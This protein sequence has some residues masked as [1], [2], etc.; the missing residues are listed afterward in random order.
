MN[1]RQA[2]WRTLAGIAAL[3]VIAGAGLALT[4]APTTLHIPAV[5]VGPLPPA[6]P[7]TSM[8]ISALPTGT[9]ETPAMLAFRGGSWSDVRHFAA[10]AVLVQH[11]NGNLLIDTGFG[12]HVGEHMKMLPSIQ[13]STHSTAV[14][15]VD[16]LASGGI[17]PGSLAGVIPTHAH[18]DH[19]SGLDDLGNVPVMV[20]AAAKRWIDTKAKGTEVI[21]SLRSINYRQYDFTGGPYLG[22]PR[23]HD[24][25]GDGSVVIVPAP[26]HTPD[27]VVV[28]ISLPS[29]TRYALVGDLVWQMEGIELPADKPWMLRRLIGENSAEVHK[30][31][32]I[33]RSAIATYPQIHA[34]PAHDAASFR[35]IPSFPAIAQ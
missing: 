33:L 20:S 31:I 29:G 28:F 9:Y 17:Q 25:W 8:S 13:R 23:S 34:I 18:W 35:L 15:A 14:A 12:K 1:T 4:F 16:Q 21:N 32:A 3:I 22:F 19:I 24:V 6:S 30:D 26:A 11:P 5:D 2:I 7:P 10:T 27:S